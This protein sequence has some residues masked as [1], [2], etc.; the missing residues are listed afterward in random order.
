MPRFFTER[1]ENVWNFLPNDVDFSSLL[2][3]KRTIR[4]VDLSCFLKCFNGFFCVC[5]N[6]SLVLTLCAF[7]LLHATLHLCIQ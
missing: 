5:V 7:D 6:V 2:S 1:V 4:C 3:F